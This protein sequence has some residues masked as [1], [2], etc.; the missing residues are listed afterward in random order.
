MARG[1]DII[2]TLRELIARGE[3]APGQRMAEIPV[4]ARLGVSRTPVRR[5]LALLAGE[6]LLAPAGARG[7]LVR[8]FTLKDILDA[9]E[10]RGTLE[11]M[12]ARQVA[13]AG[14]SDSLLARLDACLAEGEEILRAPL[15]DTH[16]DTHWSK[17]N[18]RFHSLIVG[19]C[20]NRAL[21]EALERN[22]KLPFASAGALLGGDTEDLALRAS[23]REVLMEAQFQHRAIV[24]A[25]RTRQGARAEALMREHALQGHRNVMLF[26]DSLPSAGTPRTEHRAAQAVA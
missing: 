2:V 3:F 5:A 9:I 22:D 6:G 16:A 12:A 17:M 10:V 21:A 25:L 23:H 13:E 19:G 18:V 14:P 7:Y 20:G 24:E 4:A 1:D 15:H 11:G 26:Q 8:A